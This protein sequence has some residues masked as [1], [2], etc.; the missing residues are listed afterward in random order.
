MNCLRTTNI[1]KL[2][3]LIFVFLSAGMSLVSYAQEG[4]R[5]S[6]SL[7]EVVVQSYY[8]NDQSKEI[9]A[10]LRSQDNL[11][12][13]PQN[14]QII[15]KDILRDQFV[16]NINES[17]TKNV[18]GAFREHLHNMISPDIYL[19][20]GYISAQRNGVDLRPL[21][22]GPV[23]DDISV[24][25]SIQ[26]IKGPANFMTALSDPAGSY[27]VVTK[28]PTGHNRRVVDLTYGSFGYI[29]GAVDLDGV[30]DKQHKW[31][32]RLNLMGLQSGSFMQF[33]G[34]NRFVMA[35]SIRYQMTPKTSLTLEYIYQK[36]DYT[37]LSEAQISPDGYGSLPV[38]FTLTDP[39]TKPYLAEDHQVFLHFQTA[40]S[41]NITLH[42]QFANVHNYY[43]GRIFWVYGKDNTVPQRLNRYFVY[44]AM[45]Y[46]TTSAQS[47]IQGHWQTGSI[48]H[49]L[50]AG[51]DFNAKANGTTDTWETSSTT[52]PLDIFHPVYTQIY[53]QPSS[54]PNF[55]SDNPSDSPQ[56]TT[57][58]QLWY[59]AAHAMYQIS[60]Y[61]NKLSI[62][63][64]GRLTN[65][66]GSARVYT[67]PVVVVPSTHFTPRIGVN[68]AI[69]PTFSVYGLWDNSFT[70]RIGIDVD[71]N[72]LRPMI[73]RNLEL[74][75][76]KD[77]ADGKWNTSVAVY[78]IYRNN[79]ITSTPTHNENYQKGDNSAQGV[80][81]DLKG[82]IAKGLNVIVNYAYTDSKILSSEDEKEVGLT[83]PNLIKHTHNLWV[84]YAL[85]F[86]SLRGIQ[87]SGGYQCLV[88]RSTRFPSPGDAHLPSTLGDIFLLD[89]GISYVH[90]KWSIRGICQNLLNANYQPTGWYK[91]GLYY[92]VQGAPVNFRV[93][94][95]IKI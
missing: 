33:A 63:I 70:P 7:G 80:E 45:K 66:R 87:L 74:G 35:P 28:K 77:F 58:R 31:Q 29:R 37:L 16:Y 50:L 38:D 79:F 49:K 46:N 83:T 56:N 15:G 22:K 5:D 13:V 18:S 27:N 19:R 94:L 34:H 21:Q 69:L 53:Q 88:G 72:P 52:Y 76:K 51:I 81:L 82:R 30:F 42:T 62:S 41:D 60:L 48:G 11:L 12:Q 55:T 4:H 44:D 89:M 39:G 54:T 93:T 90:E 86:R 65:A 23:A 43:D 92:W 78:H 9:D 64:G 32:Y 14:I 95:S 26:F 2:R 36:L 24:I 71:K 84:N 20:G 73:G 6:L 47:F 68:Y 8:R 85:P 3:M 1:N 10:S 17:V 61:N 67:A 40:L 59:V 75:L 91:S 25:E 57:R